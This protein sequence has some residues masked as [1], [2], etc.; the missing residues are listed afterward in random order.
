MN[1]TEKLYNQTVKEALKTI[2]NLVKI[3]F[4][5]DTRLTDFV[6]AMGSYT[7]H[8]KRKGIIDHYDFDKYPA[9][10]PVFEFIDEWDEYLKLSGAGIWF[11][12][13]GTK[14]TDW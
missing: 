4:S 2:E 6:L 12:S 5:E 13:D 10:R 9:I 3:A 7:F 14:I 11:K 8:A 1:N